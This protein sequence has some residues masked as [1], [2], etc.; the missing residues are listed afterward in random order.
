M[1]CNEGW[2]YYDRC[3]QPNSVTPTKQQLN[4]DA[5]A[6]HDNLDAE[7]SECQCNSDEPFHKKERTQVD[8]QKLELHLIV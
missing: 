8:E 4:H 5:W 1:P 6:G 3:E 2:F 7:N